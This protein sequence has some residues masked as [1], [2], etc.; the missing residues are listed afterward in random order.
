M[1]KKLAS[2]TALYGVSS[3][4][5][6]VIGYLLVPLHTAVFEPEELAP[7]VTLYAWVA[8]FNLLYAFGMETA[9][10]RFAT[11]DRNRTQHI[12]DVSL[13]AVGAVS[14]GLSVMLVAF[15]QPLASSFGIGGRPEFITWMA[16]IMIVDACVGLPFARLRLEQRPRVFVMIRVANILLN[17][18]LNFYFLWFCRGI[19]EGRFLP[20][21]KN[22]WLFHYSPQLGIGYIIFANL[23]ANLAILPMLWPYLRAF[24]PR[25]DAALFSPMFRYAYPLLLMGLAGCLNQVL[26]RIVLERWLPEGFYPGRSSAE[27]LGIYGQCY[28]LS[29]FMS[30]VVQ[31]FRYAADPFFFSRAED[32]NAPQVFADV[33]KWFLIAG[34]LIWVG[35]CLNLDVLS[36]LFLRR[37]IYWEGLPV[38][39][40][41]LLGNLFIGIYYNLAVWFKLTDRTQFG[42]YLT[43]LGLAV[44][45]LGNYLL[46]PVLGYMGSA[47]AFLLSAAAMTLVCYLLGEKYFPVPYRVASGAGYLL[48]GAA[49]IW[50]GQALAPAALPLAILYHTGLLLVFLLGTLWAERASLPASIRRRLPFQA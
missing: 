48:A 33:M 12:F 15:S 49:V 46:I 45:V 39:P 26:D 7:Q 35:V 6:R 1:L 21:L 9:F 11:R 28:K 40:I 4:L 22:Y 44:T 10:F 5:G 31:A 32:R 20:S 8:V 2:D 14:V 24:R 34:V 19:A 3:I 27:A 47:V 38:V 50:L 23:L 13:T 42:T 16:L 18:G 30:L 17:V 43:V 29:I 25:F 36:M 41:L 37:K